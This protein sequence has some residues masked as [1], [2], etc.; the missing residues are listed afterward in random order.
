MDRAARNDAIA[1]LLMLAVVALFASVT[2]QIFVDPRDP[3]FGARDFPVMVLLLMAALA[4]AQGGLALVRLARSDWHVYEAGEAGPVLRYLLPMLVL[5]FVYVWLLELF[6]YV[7]PTFC[8]LAAS[9]AIF[10][11]RGAFRLMAVPLIVTVL[12]YFLF[13]GVFGLNEPEGVIV[14]YESGGF[15][16]PLRIVLGLQ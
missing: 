3:G 4:L 6:Q 1:A 13:F 5:G 14:S 10:G 12:F 7:L 9:L 16:R 2:A 11:N 15:F 8:A